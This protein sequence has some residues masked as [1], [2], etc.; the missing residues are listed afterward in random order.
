MVYAPGNY[1]FKGVPGEEG[2]VDKY[3]IKYTE[4]SPEAGPLRVLTRSTWAFFQVG[5]SDKDEYL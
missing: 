3:T 2:D 1:I 4:V 5:P